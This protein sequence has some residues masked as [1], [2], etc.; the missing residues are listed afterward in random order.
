MRIAIGCDHAGF[1]LKEE[2]KAFLQALGH[3]VEDVGTHSLDSVD[4]PDFARMVA[5]A[6]AVGRVERGIV[7]CGTGIGSSIVANKVPG[8]RAAL[9]HESYTA[10]M[11]REHNDA[12]VLALGGRVLGVELAKEIVQ[13]WLASEFQGGRHARRVEKIKSIEREMVKAQKI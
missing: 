8:V 7:I 9:C 5:E 3:E 10:R 11:S 13:V 4:Y 6:V 2:I 12:N 1:L